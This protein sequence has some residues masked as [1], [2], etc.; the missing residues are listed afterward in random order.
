M[1]GVRCRCH[2]HTPL[3]RPSLHTQLPERLGL[4]LPTPHAGVSGAATA[5][6]EVA[7]GAAAAALTSSTLLAR[8]L[9]EALSPAASGTAVAALALLDEGAARANDYA[10]LFCSRKRFPDVRVV[11]GHLCFTS[12]LSAWAL[13]VFALYAPARPSTHLQP[14]SPTIG[15]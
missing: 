10:A 13:H 3:Q 2:S 6:A 1:A 8:L 12:R 11:D 15:F 14:S 5:A 7:A 4:Q 9:A